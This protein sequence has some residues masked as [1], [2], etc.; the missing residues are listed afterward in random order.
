MV[1]YKY[2]YGVYEVLRQLNGKT[3]YTLYSGVNHNSW[4][5]AFAE[6]DFLKWMFK[7]KKK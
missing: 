2:S 1:P 7:I 3:R 6:P 4:D 5:V